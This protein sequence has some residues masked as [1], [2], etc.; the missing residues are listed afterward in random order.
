M[1][2]ETAVVLADGEID[3]WYPCVRFQRSLYAVPRDSMVVKVRKPLPI[4]YDEFFG[5]FG[6]KSAPS[7][8]PEKWARLITCKN[9]GIVR[10]AEGTYPVVVFDVEGYP[11]MR[12]FAHFVPPDVAAKVFPVLHQACL[13]DPEGNDLKL[14]SGSDE[15][16][17]R[18]RSRLDGLAWSPSDCTSDNNPAGVTKPV[19]PSPVM[20]RWKI[21]PKNARVEWCIPKVPA[22]PAAK[23][24][25]PATKADAKRKAELPPGFV[26]NADPALRATEVEFIV[27]LP[28]AKAARYDTKQIGD[29]LIITKYVDPDAVGDEAVEAEGEEAGEE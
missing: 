18:A 19:M 29:A 2:S 7:R 24:N 15:S 28:I 23:T 1:A 13:E 21:L 6:G 4:T 8:N 5:I 26:V 10:V 12:H 25:A 3:T 16:R 9:Y 22:T 14:N 27:R 17:E 20:A 11:E